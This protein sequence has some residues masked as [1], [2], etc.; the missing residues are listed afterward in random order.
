MPGTAA[1]SRSADPMVVVRVRLPAELVE[2]ID[3][4]A[5]REGRSRSSALRHAALRMFSGSA[6]ETKETNR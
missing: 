5:A 6:K 3:A 2:R 1:P 4:H